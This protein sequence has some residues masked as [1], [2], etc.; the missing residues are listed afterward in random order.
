MTKSN[1]HASTEAHNY[2]TR[3]WS[4]VPVPHKKKGPKTQESA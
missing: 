2:I 3:G 1:T 4:P